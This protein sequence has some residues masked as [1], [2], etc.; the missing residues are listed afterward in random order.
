MLRSVCILSVLFYSAG[1]FAQTA[2]FAKG[3]VILNNGDTLMGEM[4]YRSRDGLKDKIY[5]KISETEKKYLPLM[6]LK[7]FRA[8]S[9]QYQK[10]D[11]GKKQ[12][13]V[14]ELAFGTI[15]LV[16]E[17][18]LRD[19]Q[20]QSLPAYRLYFRTTDTGSWEEVKTNGNRWREQMS[21]AMGL[22][23]ETSEML[24]NKQLTPDDLGKIVRHYNAKQR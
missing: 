24:Q 13:F 20:G 1:L 15:D 11:L 18:Y 21:E 6:D 7:G 14:K 2:E 10:I 8:D 4:R 17:E 9:L 23:P 16:E 3:Y 12:V 22:N 5:L 19:Y